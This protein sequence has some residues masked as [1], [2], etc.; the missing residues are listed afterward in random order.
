MSYFSW[1]RRSLTEVSRCPRSGAWAALRYAGTTEFSDKTE[2]HLSRK[3]EESQKPSRPASKV[4]RDPVREDVEGTLGPQLTEGRGQKDPRAPKEGDPRT[5]M[6]RHRL[7]WYAVVARCRKL[8]IQHA[9]QC[10]HVG[11]LIASVRQEADLRASKRQ[12]HH[13]QCR[14]FAV[15]RPLVPAKLHRYGTSFQILAKGRRGLPQKDSYANVVLSVG[16]TMF[17]GIG[18]RVSKELIALAPSTIKFEVVAPLEQSI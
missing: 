13:Y 16:A 10:A 18:E 15:P 14:A 1:E 6:S 7:W 4:V 5:P 3:L 12:H 17:H 9:T 2:S 8:A 11:D